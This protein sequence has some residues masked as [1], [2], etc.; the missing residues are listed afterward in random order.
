M[1]KKTRRA[2]PS[3]TAAL[4]NQPLPGGQS[5]PS[6]GE[7]LPRPRTPPRPRAADPPR[8]VVPPP[9]P[10]PSPGGGASDV[11]RSPPTPTPPPP[12]P[13]TDAPPAGSFPRGRPVRGTAEPS[14]AAELPGPEQ[15]GG[16]GGGQ[17]VPTYLPGAVRCCPRCR[18]RGC[19]RCPVLPA[20]LPG[21]AV[22]GAALPQFGKGRAGGPSKSGP[23]GVTQARPPALR[24]R[25]GG[26]GAEGGRGTL[27][28]RACS[29]SR[30]RPGL[31]PPRAPG[32]S[33]QGRGAR[34]REGGV[35]E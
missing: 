5:I 20:L 22:G 23:G 33:G 21:G 9:P 35:G 12:L 3:V 4:R 19:R 14:G 15:A 31:R 8:V 17:A 1:R 6:R 30:P 27:P 10:P 13:A 28:L 24:R 11:P 25:G 26:G 29:R 18:P 34:W 32:D 7:K 2:S 16:G